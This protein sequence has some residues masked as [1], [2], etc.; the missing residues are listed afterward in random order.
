M[1]R[2]GE[3]PHAYAVYVDE[4]DRVWASEWT[5]QVMPRFDPQTEKFESYRS[6]SPVANVRQIHG[7][8]G[9]VWTPGIGRGQSG[10]LPLQV[11]TK[12]ALQPLRPVSAWPQRR[13]PPV[14]LG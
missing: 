11:E 14:P 7:R 2:P 3:S 1:A 4:N 10:G 8:R 12:S 5:A 6:S 9:E 13:A